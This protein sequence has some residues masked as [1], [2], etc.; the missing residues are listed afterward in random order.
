MKKYI[1]IELS[2]ILSTL[3]GAIIEKFVIDL[4][5]HQV[6]IN[7]NTVINGTEEKHSLIFDGVSAYY[8]VGNS[9]EWRFN[10]TTRDHIEIT[11]I[12]F[13]GDRE[14]KIKQMNTKQKNKPEYSTYANFWLDIWESVLMIEAKQITIDGRGFE[15]G[16][17]SS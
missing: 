7:T 3:E 11:D 8:Y 16:Y 14:I 5:T 10:P 2:N 9:G 12:L 13:V 6:I 1:E 15:V 17:P 4:I